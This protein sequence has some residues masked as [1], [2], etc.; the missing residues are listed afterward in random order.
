V[1]FEVCGCHWGYARM[2]HDIM[3][4]LSVVLGNSALWWPVFSFNKEGQE[5]PHISYDLLLHPI[6]FKSVVWLHSNRS[7]CSIRRISVQIMETNV[8]A[9]VHFF[10][11]WPYEL[12]MGMKV[13]VM[14]NTPEYQ[15]RGTTALRSN[16][17]PVQ[18][19]AWSICW[20]VNAS[21]YCRLHS[22]HYQDRN[23]NK[24]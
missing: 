21:E 5:P 4:C 6:Q 13:A 23:N 20:Y 3:D 7:I 18:S 10:S 14:K 9:S 12:Y 16:I 2:F 24:P 17:P 1:A 15:T 22:L 11:V 8:H 19:S